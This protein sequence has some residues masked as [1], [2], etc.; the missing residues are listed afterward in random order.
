MHKPRIDQEIERTIDGW[1]CGLIPLFGEFREDL[2]RAD[3]FVRAPDDFEYAS[4]DRR[5]IQAALLTEAG[6]GIERML[7]AALMV[8]RRDR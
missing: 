8:V 5:Q 4:A 1:W 6:G 2:I 7:D 3:R